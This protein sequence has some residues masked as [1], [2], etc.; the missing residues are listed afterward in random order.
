MAVVR[1]GTRSVLSA[2]TWYGYTLCSLQT[3]L[4]VTVSAV[5][6][7][8]TYRAPCQGFNNSLIFPIL[9]NRSIL[10]VWQKS[11][12]I[13]FN[14]TLK[15]MWGVYNKWWRVIL[16]KIV[17]RMRREISELPKK[18]L[19]PSVIIVPADHYP[20]SGLI[21]THYAEFT[22]KRVASLCANRDGGIFTVHMDN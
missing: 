17:R 12:L 8:Q 18:W 1:A 3:R 21:I 6:G 9:R 7:T 20:V 15:R 19:A 10:F 16:T 5:Q 22:L 14:Y 13:D 4:W 2:F 11:R